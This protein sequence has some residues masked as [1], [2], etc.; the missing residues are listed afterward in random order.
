VLAARQMLVMS[1]DRGSELQL[2]AAKARAELAR[3]IG[4]AADEE[5]V[6]P[7]LPQWPAPPSLAQMKDQLARHPAHAVQARSVATA[8]ADF[9]LAREA[10]SP[11]KTIEIGYGARSR[12]FTNMVSIQFSMDLPL[13][14]KD[15]QQ[16]GV[17]ARQAQL[18][19]AEAMREDHL[20]MLAAELSATYAMW[21]V[22]GERIKRMDDELLPNAKQRVGAALAAYRGGRGELAAVLEARRAEIDARLSRMEVATQEARAR[23]QLAYFEHL[24]DDHEPNR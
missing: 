14:P 20:R 3:W 21:S 16:R 2:E 13:A 4:A 23:M 7:E 5:E 19:K 9:A 24:G 11:D 22:A 6:E 17:A 1:R 18:E 10:N 8:E 12:Q 15:R